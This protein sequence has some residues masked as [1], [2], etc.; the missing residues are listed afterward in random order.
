MS[1]ELRYFSGLLVILLLGMNT[2]VWAEFRYAL[3]TIAGEPGL[4][5]GSVSNYVAQGFVNNQSVQSLINLEQVKGKKVKLIWAT[6]DEV[7][8]P[9]TVALGEVEVHGIDVLI[10]PMGT[11]WKTNQYKWIVADQL[12]ISFIAPPDEQ[13]L[14]QGL[15]DDPSWVGADRDQAMR[16]ILCAVWGN[17]CPGFNE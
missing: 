9:D 1:R 12:I 4:P 5:A 7:L 16:F 17:P 15:V 3:Y 6:D 8:P 2:P 14:V 10:V 13:T 11:N